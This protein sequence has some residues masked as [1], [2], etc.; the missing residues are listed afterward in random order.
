[1]ARVVRFS[2]RFNFFSTSRFKSQSGFL[3]ANDNKST[4]SVTPL[5]EFPFA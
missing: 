1:M 5:I 2:K 4:S 3:G